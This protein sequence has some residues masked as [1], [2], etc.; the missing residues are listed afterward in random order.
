[1]VQASFG[2]TLFTAGNVHQV[3]V[4]GKEAFVGVGAFNMVRRDTYDRTEGLEWLRMEPADDFALGLLLYRHQARAAFRLGLEEL[5]VRWYS[6]IS[7]MVRGLEKNTFGPLC[8]YSYAHLSLLIVLSLGMMVAPFLAIST[9]VWWLQLLG[10]IALLSLPI[11]LAGIAK[12]MK[13]RLF[14][15]V[16]VPIGHAILLYTLVRAAVLCGRQGGVKWRG[17]LYTIEELK[18][19]RRI[20]M[21]TGRVREPS[22]KR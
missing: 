15:S 18:R 5:S 1:M 13:M 6:S 14:P 10:V 3:G 22:L 7:E 16:F 17:T 21:T 4:P 12:S 2:A 11:G 8:G 20:S 9:G 19:G